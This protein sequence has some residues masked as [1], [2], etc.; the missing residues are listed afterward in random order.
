MKSKGYIESEKSFSGEFNKSVFQSL[1]WG[2]S[3]HK[4]T[5]IALFIADVIGRSSLLAISLVIGMWVDAITGAK[6][7]FLSGF[8]HL[9]FGLLLTGLTLVGFFF[10]TYYLIF[11]SRMGVTTAMEYLIE[12][13][14]RVS[15]AP[16]TFFD[17]NPVGRIFSRFSS[18]FQNLTRA[19][20]PMLADTLS[21][22]LTLTLIAIFTAIANI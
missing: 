15:R 10:S 22:V 17:K 13:V 19:I 12:T 1:W 9:Q 16:T 8:S 4:T 20:G 5:M 18:D 7:N 11:F 6:V 14:F 3:H 2:L 21:T